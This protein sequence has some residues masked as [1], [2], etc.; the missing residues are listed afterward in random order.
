ME[1]EV[2]MGG[3]EVKLVAA[4]TAEI[5]RLTKIIEELTAANIAAQE[6]EPAVAGV[7]NASRASSK[8]RWAIILDEGND[9]NE[10]SFQPVGVNGRVYQITRG[11]VVEVPIEVLGVLDH[12][13][14]DKSI[15]TADSATGMP[16]GSTTR[17][18]RRFPY[19]KLGKAIDIDGVRVQ[20]FEDLNANE[21]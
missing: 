19:Q 14:L 7:G 6:T 3:L 5:A 17:K 10:L 4:Q 12:A 1:P 8:E 13:V 21:V 16:N 11:R 15:T 2:I 20:T 9:A 18:V